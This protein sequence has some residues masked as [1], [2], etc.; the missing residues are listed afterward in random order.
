MWGALSDERTGLSFTIAADPRQRSHSRVR[1]PWDS[2]PYFT[3]SDV[4]LPFSSPPTT[5]RATVEVLD[6]VS[7]REPYW[8]LNW[9][10]LCSFWADRRGTTGFYSY[11]NVSYR[12]ASADICLLSRCLAV[13]IFQLRLSIIM[14]EVRCHGS[15]RSNGRWSCRGPRWLGSAWFNLVASTNRTVHCWKS[16]LSG[17]NSLI[18]EIFYLR[19][20]SYSHLP[21]AQIF[22][23]SGHRCQISRNIII[24]LSN[25]AL[26]LR[27]P[28]WEEK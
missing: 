22:L 5:R 4:R 13:N 2:L 25:F 1:V 23:C 12:S 14:L 19:C 24:N 6:P 21:Y 9:S 16:V 15:E 8:P 3:V 17:T 10:T 26:I 20:A 7:T 18:L 28:S 11:V 27:C